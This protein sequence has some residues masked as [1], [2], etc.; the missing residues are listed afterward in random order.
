MFFINKEKT[1]LIRKFTTGWFALCMVPAILLVI[2]WKPDVQGLQFIENYEWIPMIGAKYQLGVDGMALVL[3]LLTALLGVLAA[4]CSW[5]YI[6]TR[7]K[8]YYVFLL[9]LQT[10]MLGVFA[11][12]D[13]FLFYVFFEVMLVP[14]YFLIGIWGGERRLYA[15]IKFFLYTLV[16][17]VLMLL[18]ILKLYFAAPGVAVAHPK[19][20]ADSV[21]LLVGNNSGMLALVQDGIDVARNA[22]GPSGAA[23]TF[24]L[25]A[26]QALGSA[27]GADG[28]GFIP[29][30][31]QLW[32]FAGFAIGFMI[33]VPMFPFHTW[34]PDA[35][36]EAPTAGSVVL[37][38]VLLKIGTYG[39]LRFN[40]PM[41]PDAAKHPVTLSVLGTLAIIGI[42][43]GSLVAMAQKDM[44]KL[45]AYS[46]V[47]HMGLCMLSM[48]ALNP[49]GINGSV[50]QMLNHG[51]STGALFLLVGVIYER[52]HTR[53][54][55][56]FG[57][58]ANVVPAY[59]TI[60]FI[61]T[62]S[63]IGVPLLN[64]FIGEFVGLRGVLEAKVS[65]AFWGATGIILGAA[66]MLWLYQRVFFGTVT[67]PRNEGL[68]DLTARE[69]AYLLP[70]VVL[71]FW[72]GIYP[73]PVMKYIDGPTNTIVKQV[74]PGYFK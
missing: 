19:E 23:G 55:S 20:V 5:E 3:V 10:G 41:F 56:E 25:F 26:L 32:M 27:R 18:A 47:G 24:N 17:S 6:T 35:H 21:A 12:A 16:G 64:G 73:K 71:M 42:V 7:T 44:K 68:S 11:A 34:L 8:E 39:F 29:L 60:F 46:S 52:R 4:L 50:L 38:G 54:I 33:K 1:D 65:W 66:Y 43:Y 22:G 15:A 2:K 36:V 31:W 51:I 9:L 40:F 72:I 58:L 53:Q 67:N 62:L 69:W 13:L 70:L 45:V 59:A 48:L 61:T 28:L 63:S 14:M 37:A 74:S 57:G 49:N 30:N